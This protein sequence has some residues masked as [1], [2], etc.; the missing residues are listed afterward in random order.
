MKRITIFFATIAMIS[1]MVMTQSCGKVESTTEEASSGWLTNFVDAQTTSRQSGKPIFAFFTGSDWCGWCI[2]LHQEVLGT[3][4][5]KEYASANMVL[6]EADFPRSKQLPVETTKQNEEL[7]KQ[8]NVRGFPTI[9]LLDADGKVL[10]QLGY[11]AGG[12]AA[13]VERLKQIINQD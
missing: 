10:G 9:Y 7:A 12:G 4:D 11:A 13:Y 5:F 1:G 8:Y 6:F 2:K 3:A